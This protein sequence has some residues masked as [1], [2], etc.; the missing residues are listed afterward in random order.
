LPRSAEGW[1]ARRLMK[2]YS[3]PRYG[4]T[5]PGGSPRSGSRRYEGIVG[6]ALR[7]TT[8][9]FLAVHA[10]ACAAPVA[11]E[12]PQASAP[13][14]V[15]GQA[16]PAVRGVPSVVS[17]SS[18]NDSATEPPTTLVMDQLGL[19][20]SP[21]RMIVRL[22]STVRFTNSETLAHNV[23]L[24]RSGE[25]T[26]LLDEDT[27]PGDAVDYVTDAVGG[28]EVA[29]TAHPG[30]TAFIF[31]TEAAHSVFAE[32]DGSFQLTGAPPGPYTLSVWSVAATL[33]AQTVIDLGPDPLEVVLPP[34]G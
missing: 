31:V 15:Y 20:F 27:D 26:S 7:H 14:G 22:G 32:S 6:P 3:G 16:A 24:A 28:I 11:E 18:M 2:R 4:A 5:A 33:R 12:V 9:W 19:A 34:H 23:R 29:C 21:A 8:I 10:L 17:L 25:Q 13:D 30:M 1:T